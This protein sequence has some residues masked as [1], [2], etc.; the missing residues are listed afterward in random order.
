MQPKLK[1]IAK[2]LGV[3][4]ATVSNVLSG[5]GRVSEETRRLISEKIREIGYRPGGPGRA[6]RT[7]RSGVL[8]LVLP[9]ISNPLFPAFA[10]AIEAAASRTGHGILIAD[11]HGDPTAQ[12][13]ALE[14]I[15]QRGAD[16]IVIVP[17][18]GTQV[19]GLSLPTAI[20]DSAATPGN[21]VCADHFQGGRIA[22]EHLQALGHRRLVL[23][24]H[25][26]RSSVQ[27]ARIA[28][29]QA[30]LA[31]E[32]RADVYWLEE[33][34]P[35]FAA[36][37]GD[38]A[39]AFA[40][41]SD[42]HALTALTRLQGAGLSVPGD[43]SV[44]GFDDLSFSAQITPGLTTLAQN[45]PEIAAAAVQHLLLQLEAVPLPAPRLVPMKLLVRGSTGPAPNDPKHNKTTQ[46]GDVTT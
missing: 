11:S 40:A 2:E 6:L 25:S 33:A 28:G 29:M 46:Q 44:L 4:T 5:K 10:Q 39:T 21:S 27:T 9:D 37:A 35:D 15:M 31:P 8:G 23:L 32:T 26:R 34:A 45:M 20:I 14:R 24:G 36:L 1:D 12:T 17:C 43:V 7:G 3:S 18:R 42:L 22:V 30:A 16:G 38:G 13:E 19:S 41:T